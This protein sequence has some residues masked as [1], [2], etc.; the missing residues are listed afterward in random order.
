MISL[1]NP[2]KIQGVQVTETEREVS[3]AIYAA[4]PHPRPTVGTHVTEFAALMLKAPL[5]NR[6]LSG[7]PPIE[8]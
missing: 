7:D 5:G 1:A 4:L 8:D 3:V 2:T 6:K